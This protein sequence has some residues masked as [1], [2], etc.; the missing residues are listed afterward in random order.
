MSSATSGGLLSSSS[1]EQVSYDELVEQIQ[2]GNVSSIDVSMGQN[3]TSYVKAELSSGSTASGEQYITA[4]VPTDEFN[5]VLND[6]TTENPGAIEV[7]Y[8][9]LSEDTWS[10]ILMVIMMVV[11]IGFLFFLFMSQQGEQAAEK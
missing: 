2:D 1:T 7:N 8:A 9:I 11:F 3:S 6:Y 5:E 4:Y 10:T